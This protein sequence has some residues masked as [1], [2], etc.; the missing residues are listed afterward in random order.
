M[1]DLGSLF[2]ITVHPAELILRG[3]VM[4]WFLFLL[5]R[6]VLRRDMG[7]IG[8]AD[9]L[10]LVII[11]DASQNALAG[12]YQSITDGM[13]LVAT[14]ASWNWLLD[15]AGYRFPVL[16]QLLEAKALPLVRNG[17]VI[18][19]NLRSEMITTDE[20]MAKLREHGIEK[21]E[22]VKM[23]TMESDGEISVI[24]FQGETED[25]ARSSK[26]KLPG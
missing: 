7:S 15:W 6:F 12:G 23:A 10:L 9:V 11:A 1:P 25:N 4:Y 5:F 24:K 3:T 17:R 14:I 13:I 18:R 21:L 19:R 8:V 16:R 2:E 26:D 22:Q 20:L